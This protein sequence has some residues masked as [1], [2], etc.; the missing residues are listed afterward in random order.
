MPPA[1]AFE[2]TNGF[3]PEERIDLAHQDSFVLGPLT[4]QPALRRI[5]H[6]DGEEEFLQPR[7]MQVLVALFR[8][9]GRILSRDDLI[10]SCWDGRIVGEASIDRVISQLRRVSEGIGRRAFSIETIKRVGYRLAFAEG[11]SAEDA[12]STTAVGNSDLQSTFVGRLPRRRILVF[13][14]GAVLLA[15]A[16]AGGFF[17]RRLT[18]PAIPPEAQALIAQGWQAWAQATADGPDQALG[19]FRRATELAPNYADAWGLLGCVYADASHRDTIERVATLRDHSRSAAQQALELDPHNAYARVALAY[20]RPMMGNW[21]HMEREFQ[22]SHREQPDRQIVIHAIGSTLL[23]VGRCAEAASELKRIRI[24][25][26]APIT[27]LL[28][29]VAEWGANR[30]EQADRLMEEGVGLYPAHSALWEMN[31]QLAMFGGN[32]R[33]A[34]ALIDDEQ[35]RPAGMDQ[36]EIDRLLLLG[37]AIASRDPDKVERAAKN[38]K[39]R[40]HRSE[41]DAQNAI[42]AAAALG[43]TND[44]FVILDAF[45]FSRGFLVPDSPPQSGD[46]SEARLD[47][48]STAFLFLPVMR[49]IWA[50]PRFG[51]ITSALGLERYWQE[52][53][54]QP[55]FRRA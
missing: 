51:S 20:D 30:I 42:L 52:A 15:A 53:G 14:G 18:D 13:G 11:I 54:V 29:V 3:A 36:G 23:R 35:A 1:A 50:D 2:Q 39:A 21:L 49:P 44:A 5:A 55:D 17:I 37:E 32:P 28:R 19:F 41:I 24:K 33:K 45:Y 48:R 16:S 34:I 38:E 7:V 12:Y 47:E 40:A 27:Y 26:D 4:I 10:Q 6:S 9:N 46:A 31:L 25:P 8:A 22:R 43:R